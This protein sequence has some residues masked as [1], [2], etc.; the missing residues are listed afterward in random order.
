MKSRNPQITQISQIGR[1][2]EEP[3]LSLSNEIALPR[4]SVCHLCN[5]RNLRIT[6][7][8]ETLWTS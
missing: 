8:Q 2:V 7:S 4:L 6:S 1:A 5:L 3:A